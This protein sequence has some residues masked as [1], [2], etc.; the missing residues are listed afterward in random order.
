MNICIIG[1]GEIGLKLVEVLYENNNIELY[2][3]DK[4][5]LLNTKLKYPNIKTLT[6]DENS[7]F[8][9]CTVFLCVKPQDVSEVASKITGKC[10]NFCSF[11]GNYS[12]EDLKLMFDS[13]NYCKSIIS[14]SSNKTEQNTFLLSYDKV[15][16]FNNLF[17]CVHKLNDEFEFKNTLLLIGSGPA[18]IE[19]LLDNLNCF[20][21][22]QHLYKK[23]FMILISDY[24]NMKNNNVD[25]I[26][27]IKTNGGL[28]D[29]ILTN[30]SK[31]NVKNKIK[32]SLKISFEKYFN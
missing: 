26:K 7:C 17:T 28:T 2:G 8:E 22:N 21:L 12:L 27:K 5:K 23:L 6:F 24:K 11:V 13:K 25:I 15:D 1:N 29:K 30:F 31:Y 4:E 3:R 19:D 10:L 18:I 32:N 9:H 14:L 20:N 16:F